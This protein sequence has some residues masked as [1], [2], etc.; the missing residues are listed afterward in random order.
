MIFTCTC[1]LSEW[2]GVGKRTEKQKRFTMNKSGSWN[3]PQLDFHMEV[4]IISFGIYTHVQ[5]MNIRSSLDY[6]VLQGSNVLQLNGRQKKY[7]FHT[8]NHFPWCIQVSY[9]HFR[10]EVCL[11]RKKRPWNGMVKR[12]LNEWVSTINRVRTLSIFN[13]WPH[14]AGGP[15]V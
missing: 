8:H 4:A 3:K 13:G 1:M 5:L 15:I 6:C 12:G 11:Q 2:M 7:S 10:H 14:W 9:Y